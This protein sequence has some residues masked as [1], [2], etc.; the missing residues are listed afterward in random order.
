MKKI[1][2]LIT[3][4][5]L[6]FEF[7]FAQNPLVKQWDYRFGGDTSDVLTCFQQTNDEGYILAGYSLSDSNGTKTQ[8]NWDTVCNPFCTLDYWIIKI[9][10]NGN[11][12]WDKSFGGFQNDWLFSILQTADGGYLL[13]GYS[14][15]G[16]G[17][18][19]TQANWGYEDYWIVKTDSVGN[20]QWDKTF[21][22][23]MGDILYS[24]LQTSDGGYILGGASYS[25]ISGDKSQP[26]WSFSADYWIIKTDSL[27]IKQWDRDLGGTSGDVLYC[28]VQTTDGG[29]ILGGESSSPISG[30][31]TQAAWSPYSDYWIIKTDSFGI[32]QWDKDFGGIFGELLG[33]VLQTNDGGYIISGQSNSPISGDKTQSSWGNQDY[34][35]VKTDSAGIKQWD[36]DFGALGTDELPKVIS[37]SDGG[38]LFSGESYSIM[39]GDKTENNLGV[40]QTWILKTDSNGNKL[41]D[42]TI[43]TPGHD[44]NGSTIQTIDGCYIIANCTTGGIGGYKSQSNWDTTNSTNDYWL[45][46]FCDSTLTSTT[47]IQSQISNFSIYPNPT[48]NILTIQNPQFKITN[49]K[50]FNTLGKEITISKNH[51]AK[52]KNETQLNISSLRSGIYLLRLTDEK[53]NFYSAKFVK[54]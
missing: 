5:F 4:C 30:D 19:K 49:L 10:A 35:I 36:K 38:Y 16:I 18:D 32:K 42:K 23:T 44:E 45:I 9:D 3:F 33:N 47:N 12:Q 17:G 53:G 43:L 31:K 22:G 8:T 40:E 11:K 26:T 21:G 46:K 41:W 39:G 50:I 51:V 25:Q 1:F 15:S 52:N 28:V 13:G 27:G 37:T 20:K 14:E 7:A 54:E 24:L 6:F 34:W 29:Y 2:L 48:K